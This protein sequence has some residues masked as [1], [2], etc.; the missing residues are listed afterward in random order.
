MSVEVG[1]IDVKMVVP[2]D[3]VGVKVVVSDV[4]F[5]DAAEDFVVD[6]GDELVDSVVVVVF[7]V[8][9]IDELVDSDVD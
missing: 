1:G 9:R 3:D 8:E 6:K 5:C 4:N 2:E 7:D